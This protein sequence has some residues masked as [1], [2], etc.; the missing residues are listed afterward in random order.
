MIGICLGSAAAGIVAAF[1]SAASFTLSWEHTAERVRW[2][3][4]YRVEGYRLVLTEARVKG[5][6][7][8]MEP[9]ADAVLRDGWW[10]YDPG[11]LPLPELRLTLSSVGDYTLCWAGRC[12]PLSSLVAPSEDGDILVM[13][14]CDPPG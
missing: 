2:E 10:H 4:D 9:P 11:L 7:A 8:G 13:R 14:V 1:A 6:G 5:S 12:W 3:E